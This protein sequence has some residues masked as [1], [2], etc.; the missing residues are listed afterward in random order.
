M[1]FIKFQKKNIS[2]TD[3]GKGK[4]IVLLHGF[5]ESSKIWTW[6]ESELANYYRVVT[7]DLPGHGKSDCLADVHTMELM[8]D[9]VMAVLKQ[10]RTGRCLM[11]GHSLGGYVA[12]AFT[13][14]Y[15]EKLKALCLFHSHCFPDTDSERETRDRTIKL[16]ERDRFGYVA[17]FIPGLFPPEVH[18]K[19]SEPIR[20]MIRR[21]AKMENQAII[22]ALRGMKERPDASEVLRNA[23]VPVLFIIGQK[24][25]RAPLS[26]LSEMIAL[27][28]V[29]EL[30]LLRDCGHMGYLEA[31]ELTFNALAG[32]AGRY[33]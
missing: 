5:T 7:I 23:M 12:L 22:A 29:S 2:Y 6:F 4:T 28:A 31:P 33:L 1:A 17:Q 16:V 10:L 13:A 27:P 21:A 3:Q 25:T 15:P 32:F 26:R 8:A 20:K 18:K 24:D 9:A 30:L 14:K 11:T 19:L